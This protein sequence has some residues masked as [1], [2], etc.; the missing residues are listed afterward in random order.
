MGMAHAALGVRVV[1]EAYGLT[2]I[3]IATTQCDLVIPRALEEHGGVSILL[4]LMQ[5]ATWQQQLRSVPGYDA[6]VTGTIVQ[7]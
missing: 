3:P 7:R 4:N 2:F 6:T 1:A 5:S